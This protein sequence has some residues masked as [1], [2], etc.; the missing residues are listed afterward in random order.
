MCVYSM[1]VYI[2]THITVCSMYIYNI[3]CTIFIMFF[4]NYGFIYKL[5][6]IFVAYCLH[7]LLECKV[8]EG[9]EIWARFSLPYPSPQSGA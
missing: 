2:C 6:G 1:Y 4:L 7:L 3:Y 9:R 8:H 5:F